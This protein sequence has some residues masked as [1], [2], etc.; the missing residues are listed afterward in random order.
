MIII[1]YE[2]ISEKIFKTG[3]KRYSPLIILTMFV[4]SEITFEYM[5]FIF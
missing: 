4:I 2:Y 3:R 1:S 5:V